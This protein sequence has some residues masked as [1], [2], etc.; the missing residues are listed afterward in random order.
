ML[1]LN[2]AL[3]HLAGLRKL[4]SDENRLLPCV[5]SYVRNAKI[6]ILSDVRGDQFTDYSDVMRVYDEIDRT[7]I[8]VNRFLM[9][10]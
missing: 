1:T 4:A 7:E 3:S 10:G 8:A 2:Q 9:G 5:V 6:D